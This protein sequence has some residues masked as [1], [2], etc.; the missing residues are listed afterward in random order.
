MIISRFCILIFI[1]RIKNFYFDYYS[2]EDNFYYDLP[3]YYSEKIEP[4][5]TDT[6]EKVRESFS[7]K[8]E[9]AKNKINPIL[10]KVKPEK[11]NFQKQTASSVSL[12]E[13][14]PEKIDD[15]KENKGIITKIKDKLNSSMEESSTEE[16]KDT[17]KK[18][19]SAT[20]MEL[21]D[22]LDWKIIAILVS[23]FV[24]TSIFAIL[25]FFYFFTGYRDV[26]DNT[27]FLDHHR[28]ITRAQIEPDNENERIR[29]TIRY[30]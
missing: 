16:K 2:D 23:C 22:Y 27:K 17:K 26:E 7:N 1:L 19:K 8:K 29:Q 24:L 14:K 20:N 21:K 3:D 15:K 18:K 12:T 10:E 9:T 4:I 28:T 25:I 6:K 5:Y 11:P 13:K 30:G